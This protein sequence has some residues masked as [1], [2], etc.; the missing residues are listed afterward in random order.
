M[1]G[2]G[3]FSVAQ[4]RTKYY[5]ENLRLHCKNSFGINSNLSFIGY[6]DFFTKTDNSNKV[7]SGVKCILKHQIV[8]CMQCSK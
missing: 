1:H 8:K 6:N 2:E 3:Y 4:K 7:S 5:T